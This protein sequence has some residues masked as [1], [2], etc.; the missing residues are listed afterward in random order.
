VGVFTAIVASVSRRMVRIV[1]RPTDA[2]GRC[3]QA[4]QG[5]VLRHGR[6]EGRG[7]PSTGQGIRLPGARRFAFFRLEGGSMPITRHGNSPAR[8]AKCRQRRPGP[9]QGKAAKGNDG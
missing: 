8:E 1:R 2:A 3:G 9:R 7:Q 5:D 6:P 4:R